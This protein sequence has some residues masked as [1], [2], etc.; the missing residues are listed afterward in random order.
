MKWRSNIGYLGGCIF[1]MVAC[2]GGAI[3]ELAMESVSP[4]GDREAKAVGTSTVPDDLE[5]EIAR[6]R[7]TIDRLESNPDQWGS[8]EGLQELH[9]LNA[10]LDQL[11]RSLASG[12]PVSGNL[13]PPVDKDDHHL[14][15]ISVPDQLLELRDGGRSIARFPVSTS[16]FGLGDEPGS[17][18]TPPGEMCVASKVGAGEPSGMHLEDR[19]PTGFIVR[20]NQGGETV[21]V[22]RVL[23]LRGL[24]EQNRNAFSRSIYIHGTPQESKVGQ[25]CSQGCIRMKSRDVIELFDKVGIGARVRVTRQRI[26]EI[27]M[28]V[29]D[30]KLE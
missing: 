26:D 12:E 30:D 1:L 4:A 13:P 19:L 29:G 9:R 15:I 8:I 22:T 28:A 21:I 5:I 14:L 20:P 11:E 23:C 6:T 3:R 10:E 27:P 7:Q 2:E 17:R 18:Q 24:E 25:P 16:K